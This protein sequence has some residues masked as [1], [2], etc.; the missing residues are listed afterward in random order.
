MQFVHAL[1]R[2][3]GPSHKSATGNPPNTG[4]HACLGRGLSLGEGGGE[5]F[6]PKGDERPGEQRK[7]RNEELHKL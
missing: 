1:I 7:L 4:P 2:A 5:T 3:S 6:R